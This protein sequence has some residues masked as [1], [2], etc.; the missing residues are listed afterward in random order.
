MKRAALFISIGF[1]LL[2]VSIVA[3]QTASGYDLTWST[4]GGQRLQRRPHRG[5]AR[6]RHAEWR[7]LRAARRLLERRRDRRRAAYGHAHQ[8]ADAHINAYADGDRHAHVD[9]NC[10]ANA[11]TDIDCDAYHNTDGNG[12]THRGAGVELSAVL[13]DCAQIRPSSKD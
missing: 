8:H 5:A 2:G 11:H 10:D 3:A 12:H 6:C 1:L 13:T 7:R 4:S 9:A